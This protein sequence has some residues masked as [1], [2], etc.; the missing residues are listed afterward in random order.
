M[1][2]VSTGRMITCDVLIP[3]KHQKQYG[4]V[5][6]GGKGTPCEL[7]CFFQG[8]LDIK[9]VPI[10]CKSS[11]GD[12]SHLNKLWNLRFPVWNMMVAGQS[13]PYHQAK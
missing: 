9:L 1:K 6:G 5:G 7:P 8:S 11:C 10:T 12:V 4:V 3:D 13:R 2:A